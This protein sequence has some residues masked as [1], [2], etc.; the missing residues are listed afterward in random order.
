MAHS[1][2]I[3]TTRNIYWRLI[4]SGQ[5]LDLT[6]Y[7]SLF[8][9]SRLPQPDMDT[10]EQY[11]GSN[12]IVVVFKGNF[13]TLEVL[14]DGMSLD[15]FLISSGLTYILSQPPSSSHWS[16]SLLTCL[17]RKES[18]ANWNI[19]RLN[20]NNHNSERLL[21]SALWILNLPDSISSPSHSTTSP[22]PH[23]SFEGR[24]RYNY[25]PQLFYDKMNV[26]VTEDEWAVNFEHSMID[27]DAAHVFLRQV[28]QVTSSL[29]LIEKSSSPSNE[30]VIL[31]PWDFS[32]LEQTLSPLSL[33]EHFSVQQI[34]AKEQTKDFVLRI[35]RD[36][37][38]RA[39]LSPDGVIQ[40]AVALSFVRWKGFP[41]HSL[42]TID[43][44]HFSHSR[45]Q[46]VPTETLEL[47]NLLDEVKRESLAEKGKKVWPLCRKACEAHRE[48]LRECSRMYVHLGVL[49][50][51]E[52]S[53]FPGEPHP[54]VSHPLYSQLL[55]YQLVTSNLGLWPEIAFVYAGH[56]VE[57]GM[58]V[59]GYLWHSEELL[60]T[61]SG[62]PSADSFVVYL[63]ETL[64][65]ME[66]WMGE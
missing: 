47:K 30:H 58:G 49:L 33:L 37:C 25:N 8:S 16:P 9:S 36:E 38:K 32:L 21:R 55:T 10:F 56:P 31:L 62:F 23:P 15:P 43:S 64:S 66:E 29:P 45:L 22:L 63:Q 61:L 50:S 51:N 18:F 48:I 26:I 39:Q 24:Q 35:S 6:S 53:Q 57:E 41:F 14:K 13:F 20:P 12:H 28:Y 34:K 40:V 44:R 2:T 60:C 65:T 59:L 17:S 27:S 19:L 3:E 1:E 11:E 54:L 46:I 5:S 52:F 7:H 4:Q 42:E